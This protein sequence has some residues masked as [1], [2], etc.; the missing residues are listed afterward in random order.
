MISVLRLQALRLYEIANNRHILECW[1]E[2]RRTQWLS[3]GELLTLQRNKL[4][5]L[6]E[7]AYT[8]VPYYQQLFDEVRFRP[9]DFQT[10]PASFRKIPLLS[11]AIIRENFDNLLTTESQRRRQLSRVSTGGSTGQPLTFMQDNNYRDHI[12]ASVLCS[13]EWAGW[14]WGECQAYIWGTNFE[15]GAGSSLRGRLMDLIFNRF[16]TNAYVLSNE[17]MSAFVTKIR[18]RRPGLLFGYAS[19]LYSFAQFVRENK[20]DGIKFKAIFSSA[21][22]LYPP[23]RQ[24]IEETFDCKVFDRYATRELGELG[25]ECGFHT[26]FHVNVANCYIEIEKD[27][28]P[29]KRGEAGDLI[30]TNLTNYGMPFIRYSLAD[31]G[32]WSEEDRCPCGRKLP[33]LGSIDG[34][35]NDMFRTQDGHVV[36]GGFA[37][38]LW[39]MKSVKQFQFI[40]KSFDRV[41]A[42]IVKDGHLDQTNLDKIEQAVKTAL[43]DNTTVEFEFPDEILPAESGKIRYQISEV[44]ES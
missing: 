42:R 1:R 35:H 19:S 5:R 31:V 9:E 21:E 32:A 27:G 10:D 20:F 14:K 39:G 24:F 25:C 8:Y 36:W 12:T 38:P 18:R 29:V 40:Q 23:Q 37:N 4:Q 6:L 7:Y 16:E 44:S 34:R 3:R 33:L 11:K 15:V 28:R 17:S 22:V 13:L 30:V 41:V 26:G 2:L 43:G